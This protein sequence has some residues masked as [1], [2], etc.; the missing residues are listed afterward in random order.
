MNVKEF[1]SKDYSKVRLT[2]QRNCW[3]RSQRFDDDIFGNVIMN[4]LEKLTD[5]KTEKEFY[6]YIIRSYNNA[7]INESKSAYVRTSVKID[8]DVETESGIEDRVDL[9][10]I[11]EKVE[12]KFGKELTDLF[13]MW[14]K[15]YSV[16]EI[17][18]LSGKIKL[19]YQFKKIRE[20]IA[21]LS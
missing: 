4:C 7:L 5:D 11:Y 9:E 13:K 20:F 3:N 1:L 8:M 16:R 18:E 12:G 10:L 2:I 21:K 17:E 6:G 14:L 15:G 19:T